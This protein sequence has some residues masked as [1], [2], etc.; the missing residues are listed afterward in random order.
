M[1]TS[2]AELVRT[3]VLRNILV[4]YELDMSVYVGFAAT[5]YWPFSL[6]MVGSLLSSHHP[7]CCGQAA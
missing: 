4:D 6:R 7:Y 2:S 1:S 3:L 5:C